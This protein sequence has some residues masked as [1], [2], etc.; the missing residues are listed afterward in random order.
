[1]KDRRRM[2]NLR[3]CAEWT[4]TTSIAEARNICK[5]TVRSSLKNLI[6]LGHVERMEVDAPVARGTP[7]QYHYRRTELGAAWLYAD[8]PPK[9]APRYYTRRTIKTEEKEVDAPAA[10]Q[11]IDNPFIWRTYVQPTTT[12]GHD[13]YSQSNRYD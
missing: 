11:N 6:A 1:M 3:L 9:T 5:Q 8:E 4:T 7:K 10:P 2:A 13:P 12:K